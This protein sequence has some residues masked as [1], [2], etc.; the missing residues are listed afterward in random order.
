MTEALLMTS[1]TAFL[2][3]AITLVTGVFLWKRHRKQM[4]EAPE[5]YAPPGRRMHLWLTGAAFASAILGVGALS[6]VTEADRYRIEPAGGQA[7]ESSGVQ[8]LDRAGGPSPA[9]VGTPQ[10]AE[11][12]MRPGQPSQ[13]RTEHYGTNPFEHAEFD[14]LSTFSLDA[15]TASWELFFATISNGY[16]H[17][18]DTVRVE[19][20]VNSIDQ[21]YERGEA[22]SMHV[23]AAPSPYGQDRMILARVG[24][25]PP[26]ENTPRPPT[27]YV[28][29][30]DTSGSM[31][32]APLATAKAVAGQM[33]R[34]M[35]QRDRYAIVEFGGERSSGVRVHQEPT[36]FTS[37]NQF[38]EAISELT[39]GGSTPLAAAVTEA[40]EIADREA[41]NDETGNVIITVVAD[42]FGNVGVHEYRDLIEIISARARQSVTLNTVATAERHFDDVMMES[43][44]NHGN[45]GYAYLNPGDD[46]TMFGRVTAP[47]MMGP[48]PRD[49]RIQVEFNPATVIRYRLIGYENRQV[50]DHLF[51]DDSLD[52]GEPGF[53]RESTALYEMEV[54]DVVDDADVILTATLR[55]R[56][57]DQEEHAEQTAT[58]TAGDVLATFDEADRQFRTTAHMA[59]LAE[60]LRGSNHAK[61][62]DAEGMQQAIAAIDPANSAERKLKTTPQRM[63]NNWPGC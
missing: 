16:R 5:G 45:G 13:T 62:A 36:Q 44:A 52:F 20:F 34:L 30:I 11:E 7:L 56:P 32:G 10:Q 9:T 3:A 17:D 38:N 21:G 55:W 57:F 59:E 54:A 61:C 2:T 50:A 25:A 22:I 39:A 26:A 24:V 18:P 29:L 40:Y 37:A 4:R 48:G 31:S 53:N 1:A 33:A 12:P 8:A 35:D 47:S 58:L 19:D 43:L 23:D 60:H 6:L 63:G 27:S 14:N 46:A 41:D 42:G 49:A 51:R 15:D 28:F